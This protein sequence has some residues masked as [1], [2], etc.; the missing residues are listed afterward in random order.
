MKKLIMA[1]LVL[2]STGALAQRGGGG[3]GGG[4][5]LRQS[6]WI[7]RATAMDNSGLFFLGMGRNYAEAY[8]RANENCNRAGRFCRINCQPQF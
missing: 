2:A 6:T 3:G 1:C 8:V 4:R 5:G 7:C